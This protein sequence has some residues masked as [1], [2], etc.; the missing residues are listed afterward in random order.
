MAWWSFRVFGPGVWLL[1]IL[2]AVALVTLARGIT[3]P[4]PL[5]RAVGAVLAAITLA[6]LHHG[7]V[8]SSDTFASMA[9]GI[10]GLPSG[11]IGAELELGL[12]SRFGPVGSTLILLLG[13]GLGMLVA[14]DEIVL[15]IPSAMIRS[16]RSLRGMATSGQGASGP[17]ASMIAS[18][19][20]VR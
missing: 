7:F 2:G 18:R 4:H 8:T 13:F 5:V 10:P 6:G 14:A 16:F 20:T 9:G 19:W 12:G 15:A 3:I 17:F 1:L 11:L